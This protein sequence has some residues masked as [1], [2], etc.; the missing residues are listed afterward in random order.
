MQYPLLSKM[1]KDFLAIP[2]T[3]APV[4]RIF[5]GGTDLIEQRRCSLKGKTI[6]ECMCLRGWWKSE[7]DVKK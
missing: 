1:A 2:A 6:Q 7:L 3:S 5:S 4:E